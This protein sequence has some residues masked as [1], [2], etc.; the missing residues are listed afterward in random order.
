MLRTDDVVFVSQPSSGLL[1][2]WTHP[3]TSSAIARKKALDV[4]NTGASTVA[5]GCPA[6]M[7]QLLDS[8]HRYGN[9]PRIRHYISLLAESYRKESEGE[10][11]HGSGRSIS[12]FH[13]LNALESCSHLFTRYGGHAHAVGFSLR[14]SRVVEFRAHME[15]YAGTHLKLADL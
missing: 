14:S 2:T 13:L 3:D 8:T 7:M 12:A 4:A 9:M 6:C 11:A 10:E 1:R 5:T 15:D